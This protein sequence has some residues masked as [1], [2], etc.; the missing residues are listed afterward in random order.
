M[1]DY[2]EKLNNNNGNNGNPEQ[3]ILN[4]LEA[5][6]K[7]KESRIEDENNI[8]SDEDQDNESE[9]ESEQDNESEQDQD[10][11]RYNLSPAEIRSKIKIFNRDLARLR[12]IKNNLKEQLQ[13]EQAKNA[14][15]EKYILF[16]ETEKLVK[17]HKLSEDNKQALLEFDTL[18][19]RSIWAKRLA[20]KSTGSLCF[21]GEAKPKISKAESENDYGIPLIK[22]RFRNRNKPI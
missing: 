13:I 11:E 1:A 2:S 16:F 22:K 17:D 10:L 20:P 19:Q 3:E 7:Q 8:E 12:L 4:E 9:S 15:L 6:E 18:E 21:F 14:E 5:F